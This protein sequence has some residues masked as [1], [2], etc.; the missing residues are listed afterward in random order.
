MVDNLEI[1]RSMFKLDLLLN[2]SFWS[3]SY[4]FC[5]RCFLTQ[6]LLFLGFILSRSPCL[7]C[8]GM[9]FVAI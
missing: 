8:E 1:H 5:P 9:D 4:V 7:Y 3:C 2:D 6:D